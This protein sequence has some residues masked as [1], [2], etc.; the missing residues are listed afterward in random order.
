MQIEVISDTELDLDFL[1][2]GADVS[3]LS[4]LSVGRNAILTNYFHGLCNFGFK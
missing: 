2:A 3:F 1:D 4:S